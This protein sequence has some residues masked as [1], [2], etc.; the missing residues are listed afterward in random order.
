VWREPQAQEI[1]QVKFVNTRI[2][3]GL[4]W[5]TQALLILT[6]LFVYSV[7]SD[8]LLKQAAEAEGQ[9]NQAIAQAITAHTEAVFSHADSI[10]RFV[11]KDWRRLDRSAITDFVDAK[12]LSQ[13]GILQVALVDAKGLVTWGSLPFVPGTSIADREHFKAHIASGGPERFLSDPVLGR[14]SKKWSIQLTRRLTDAT[15]RFAGVVVVSINPEYF[16]ERYLPLQ[17]DSQRRITV[18]ST[19]SSLIL[20]RGAMPA[21]RPSGSLLAVGDSYAKNLVMQASQGIPAGYTEGKSMQRSVPVIYGWSR[22]ASY[23]LLT[24]VATDQQA[25]LGLQRQVEINLRWAIGI[26]IALL[27]ATGWVVSWAVLNQAK[28]VRDLEDARRAAEES[29]AFKSEFINAISHEVRGPLTNINGFAE[30]MAMAPLD[31][32][33]I[34]D[35]S[36]TILRAGEHL[37]RIVNQLLDAEKA[38][39]GKLVL[40]LEPT[41]VRAL[42]A[43]CVHINSVAAMKKNLE[44]KLN[45]EGEIPLSAW[46]DGLRF[47]QVVHNFLNNAIKFTSAGSVNVDVFADKVALRVTVRDTGPGIALRYQKRIFERF[48]QGDPLLSRIHGGTGL[49]LSLSKSLVELMGGRIWFESMV[50]VGSTFAFEIPLVH[51][52]SSIGDLPGTAAQA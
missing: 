8:S 20:A 1:E 3:L 2:F 33:T 43:Q 25:T 31:Q 6:L 46:L 36:T 48:R 29:D 7:S 17:A 18:V 10:A 30:L 23:P 28:S 4:L 34:K 21:N 32:D 49:G 22:S 11:Q 15:G 52:P 47:S 26:A 37:E 19:D 16:A 51:E 40:H 13:A 9:N 14:V 38:S 24:A 45:F 44:L 12:Q 41:D 42:I 50:E 27:L 39:L 35:Y 5:A